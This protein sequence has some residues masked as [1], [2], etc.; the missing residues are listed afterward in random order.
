MRKMLYNYTY[1]I[2]PGGETVMKKRNGLF[3]IVVFV[4]LLLLS[5]CEKN[6]PIN[7]N[8]YISVTFKGYNGAGNAYVAFDKESFYLD[9]YD[10]IR[11]K[12][13][14][15]QS[16]YYELRG[17][18]SSSAMDAF[19][20]FI[21]KAK[22]VANRDLS[23]GDTITIEWDI[24][25]EEVSKYFSTKYV[26]EN[27]T[28]IAQDLEEPT[29]FD[30]FKYLTVN[31]DGVAPW[32]SVNLD[33]SSDGIT[34]SVILDQFDDICSEYRYSI[35]KPN[36]L[37]RVGDVIKISY[38]DGNSTE[39]NKVTGFI[40]QF[41]LFPERLEMEYT[42]GNV[43]QHPET[44]DQID[45]SFFEKADEDVF[46]YLT[47]SEEWYHNLEQLEIHQY[48]RVG[49]YFK[50]P[51]K[52]FYNDDRAYQL[53]IIYKVDATS[54]YDAITDPDAAPIFEDL[55]YYFVVTYNNFVIDPQNGLTHSDADFWM[56]YSIG[57]S[58]GGS[59]W[60]I[61]GERT[62]EWY[63]APDGN[64]TEYLFITDGFYTLE[65]IE[66]AIGSTT[67]NFNVEKLIP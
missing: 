64:P 21:N 67:E 53:Y 23:N 54:R 61:N 8:E 63:F 25:E 11:F 12:D 15:A 57:G 59:F 28:L 62:D 5:G 51:L 22:V 36:D 47:T 13:S 1:S 48:K 16:V 58:I 60:V 42:V 26:Y 35:E 50:T 39:K 14:S 20:H 2:Q 55:S 65:E 4:L 33:F 17:N 10:A 18:P 6:K 45:S 3:A 34:E 40:S 56:N 9:Y 30:P 31:V 32:L 29:S 19:Y 41:G 46:N 44:I 27:I 52:S 43:P 24:D 37:I 49:C 66:T 7:L 38:L